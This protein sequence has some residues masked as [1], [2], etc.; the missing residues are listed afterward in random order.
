MIL[1]IEESIRMSVFEL[2]ITLIERFGLIVA[3]CFILMHFSA[4]RKIILKRANPGE[5]FLIAL[6]FGGFGIVGTYIGVPILG[7]IANL[8]GM[9]VI[10]A[11]LLGGPLVG[12]GAGLIAGGHRFMLGGF[13][14]LPCGLATSLE[15]LLA[16]LI[17]IYLIKENKID[18]NTAFAF[19][20]I[21]ESFHMLIVLLISK[22]FSDALALV[23]VISFPM[24]IL[25]SIGA[26]IFIEI[27]NIVLREE[28]KA[29]AIQAQKA[30]KIAR[31]TI[32]YL[33]TGLNFQSAEETV[34]IIHKMTDVTAVAITDHNKILA[35]KGS[36]EDHHNVGKEE[37]TS[38]T[39]NA[40]QTG[41]YKIVNNK[42]DIGCPVPDCPLHCGVIVPLKKKGN[43]VGTLKLYRGKGSRI[44][45]VDVE[46]A[47]GLA[48]LFSTQLELEEIQQQAQLLNRAEI[49]ALQA[50]I[51]PHFLFNAL[52]TI[53][54]FCRT[55]IEKA[56]EL[57]IHLGNFFRSTLKDGNKEL[58]SLEKELENLRSYLIIEEARFGDRIK[59]SYKLNHGNDKWYIPQFTLQPLVENAI[60]HGLSHNDNGGIITIETR[61]MNGNLQLIIE[62][63]GIGISKENL[64]KI[65]DAGRASQDG[66]GIAITNINQRLKFIYGPEYQITIKSKKGSG[67]K[68]Y[69]KIPPNILGD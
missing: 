54:S 62:D 45:Q 50:Q 12:M 69:L 42:A 11:G 39:A 15:G 63:N 64:E 2:F 4:F 35:Y 13:T 34:R 57:L 65:L 9:A 38:A 44:S 22:P 68:I 59:I 60:K 61:K 23:E 14:A 19:G 16:G 30:L 3:G 10:T 48:H 49:K 43:V 56:R 29:G 7:G 51:N 8:R 27:V 20:V 58:V 55:D 40:I 5:K 21:G 28:E 24:I 6:L 25:N 17:S 53:V 52:N 18:W 47:T 32:G 67:T 41:R 1:G 33:R 66:H 37:F 46:L 31:K 26:A 36:G